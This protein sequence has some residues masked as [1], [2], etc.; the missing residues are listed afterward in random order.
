MSTE[1]LTRERAREGE[2]KPPFLRL[3]LV[4]FL[5]TAISALLLAA[6]NEVTK[7]R[8]AAL[9]AQKLQEAMEAVQPQA[10]SFEKRDV[11]ADLV[12]GFYAAKSGGKDVGY[13]VLTAPN[14]FGGAM[15][16]LVGVDLE[17]NVTGVQIISHS[18]TAGL[19]T[20]AMEPGFLGQFKDRGGE[21]TV[22]GGDNSID[23]VSGA[24]ISS[25]AITAGVNAALAAIE[26]VLP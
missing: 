15:S 2:K 18:E 19:G 11:T 21:F 5:I 25:K 8:I 9:E 17:G 12:T 3:V 4:L 16:V 23:G 13:C 10:D 24:T 7:D 14:G 1:V 20:K 22:N 6:V 26:E